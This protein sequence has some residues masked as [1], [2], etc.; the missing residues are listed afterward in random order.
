MLLCTPVFLMCYVSCVLCLMCVMSYVCMLFYCQV[1]QQITETLLKV[2]YDVSSRQDEHTQSLNNQD[3]VVSSLAAELMGTIHKHEHK[4]HTHS[5]VT[6]IVVSHLFVLLLLRQGFF[7]VEAA[8]AGCC[9]SHLK[10]QPATPHHTP[11]HT[12]LHATP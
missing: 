10:G 4:Q 7:P 1:V 2:V 9:I 11:H 8:R 3:I 6:H 5:C 12:P